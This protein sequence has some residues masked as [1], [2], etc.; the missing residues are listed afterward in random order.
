ML[1]PSP[2]EARSL[3]AERLGVTKQ[4]SAAI[5]VEA[6]GGDQRVFHESGRQVV[7]SE[8]AATC[9]SGLKTLKW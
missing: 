5:A 3:R 6:F 4:T 8:S 2:F 1:W 9:T 7:G